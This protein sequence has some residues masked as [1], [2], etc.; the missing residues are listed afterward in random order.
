[1]ASESG[2]PIRFICAMKGFELPAGIE[3]MCVLFRS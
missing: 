3:S 2:K 1:M